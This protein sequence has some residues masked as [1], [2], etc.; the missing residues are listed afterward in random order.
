MAIWDDIKRAR[1]DIKRALGKI[2]DVFDDLKK[3]KDVI[4]DIQ[5]ARRWA[6]GRI[7]SIDDTLSN[8]PDE[9]ERIAK[10]AATDVQKAMLREATRRSL[11]VAVDL[12]D[13]VMPD[14]LGLTLGPVSIQVGDVFDKVE[15]IKEIAEDPPDDCE[16]ITEAVLALAPDEISIDLS[17]GVGFIVQSD[18]AQVGVSL[19]WSKESVLE[20]LP[21]LLRKCGVPE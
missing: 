2:D 8:L 21:T 16:S 3:V 9:M 15:A 18:S 14:S 12:I 10:Q 19:G 13:T 6:G 20:H 1:R 4:D 11:A 7:N 17:I 5:R